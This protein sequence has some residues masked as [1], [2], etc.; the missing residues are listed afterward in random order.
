MGTWE[1][2]VIPETVSKLHLLQINALQCDLRT[3]SPFAVTCSDPEEGMDGSQAGPWE[4]P[5]SIWEKKLNDKKIITKSDLDKAPDR[6][7]EPRSPLTFLFSRKSWFFPSESC[8]SD[9]EC[10]WLNIHFL[11]HLYLTHC[12][13]L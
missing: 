5:G 8:T 6:P 10:W 11:S 7:Q 1:V 13:I 9:E 12:D 2:A 3:L 4:H